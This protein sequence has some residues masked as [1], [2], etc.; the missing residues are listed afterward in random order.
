MKNCIILLLTVTFSIFRAEAQENVSIGPI[1]GVS[2]ANFR[3]NTS[4]IGSNT[5]W[6]PGLTVGGFYNYSSKSRFGFTGQLLFT[7]M[8]AKVYNKT[9]EINLSYIQVPLFA[10]FFFGKYGAPVRPKLFLGPSL[11][12]LVGAHD[13]DKNR[14]NPES[15][16]RVYN[17][18][19]LGLTFGAGVNI[20][21]VEKI[22][23]NLDAR[24]GLGLLD[25]S[26][27]NNRMTN[28]NWGI[29]AGVSF[30]LGTYNKNTGRLRTR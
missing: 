29:N 15:G 6:K 10:T 13:K 12:F 2:I 21:L 24:Y 8:G 25:V 22:W 14:L 18:F 1:A 7:Q 30:P 19:D 11:N 9:N 5:D 23:L 27:D 4:A 16:P 28:Q 17:P 26:A 20:K 3:G